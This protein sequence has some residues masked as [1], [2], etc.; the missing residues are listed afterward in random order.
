MNQITY[1]K[2]GTNRN[3]P[4]LWI[5]GVKLSAANFRR[6]DR[7]NINLTDGILTIQKT[8]TGKRKVSGRVRSGVDISI[9]DLE[10]TGLLQGFA[11]ESRVRVI[12]SPDI[13]TVTLHHEENA[14]QQRETS[15]RKALKEKNLTEGSLFTGAGISTLAIHKALLDAGYKGEVKWVVDTEIKYLQVGYTNNLAITDE[16]LAI[17]GKAEEIEKNFFVPINILSF[18]MPCSG[19]ST[20]GKSKH[21][22][23]PEDHQSSTSLFGAINAVRAA[24]P[25]VLISENVI[26]AQAAPAYVLLKAELNRLGYKIFEKILDSNDT[27]TIENRK[28]YWFVAI[29]KGLAKGFEYRLQ[30]TLSDHSTPTIADI[31]APDAPD[32][33]WSDNQY[34]KDKA[35]RDKRDGKGFATR[36]L[37]SGKENH[38][39][40]I[41]RHYNKRRSTEPFLLRDDGKER[42]FTPAEHAR[43]KGVPEEII[44]NVPTT[45]AHEV[46]GQSIDFMQAYLSMN[47]IIEFFKGNATPVTTT[48]PHQTTNQM[49]LF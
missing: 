11:P 15:F 39:E 8:P 6:G 28:R 36:Q 46:L 49:T 18:S 34:L 44:T 30:Q 14:V 16:T 1:T 7:Y 33:L 13:I 38:C 19:F 23:S 47:C 24:N 27:G 20:A 22:L 21:K 43:L 29:S 48:L 3:R 2:I 41:G 9:I 32:E 17:V 45:T 40:T 42:L 5:E 12:F 35:V 10:M 4:R 31:L 25:A 26:E 37:L